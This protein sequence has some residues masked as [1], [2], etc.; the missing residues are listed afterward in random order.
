M[1][2][3]MFSCPRRQSLHDQFEPTSP[4]PAANATRES[5]IGSAPACTAGVVWAGRPTAPRPAAR[6]DRSRPAPRA[7][8]GT[9]CRRPNRSPSARPC[10]TAAETA[11]APCPVSYALS[12]HGKLTDLGYGPAAKCADC[13]GSHDILPLD[14]PNSTLSPANR[15]HTC[16]KCHA[17]AGANFVHFSPHI[18]P[19]DAKKNPVV[20]AVQITLLTLL[21]STFAFF[22]IHSLLVVH[23]RAGRSAQARP[24]PRFAAGPDGLRALRVVPSHRPHDHDVVVPGAGLD[25]P[26]AEVP[27]CALGQV[28]GPTPGRLPVDGFLASLLRR[29]PADVDARLHGPHGAVAGP[30]P[31]A[32]PDPGRP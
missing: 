28:A 1:A 6:P 22:G 18:D 4:T 32:G 3:T 31:Q 14:D 8:R 29:D 24:A 13:H 15:V 23:S 17:N 12:M 19:S 20:H 25:G 30:G 11:T 7:T 9:T 10:R 2:R 27:R 26:A 16:G 21:Y 5:K